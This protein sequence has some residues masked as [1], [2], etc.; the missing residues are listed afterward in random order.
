MTNV[1]RGNRREEGK[2]GGKGGGNRRKGRRK[3]RRR[4]TDNQE[5]RKEGNQC[6]RKRERGGGRRGK[7]G[8]AGRVE[9]RERGE[10]QTRRRS[11]EKEVE[12]G[13]GTP[14]QTWRRRT[15]RARACGRVGGA[16][17][18]SQEGKA[19]VGEFPSA[20]WEPLIILARFSGH[21]FADPSPDA[22]LHPGSSAADSVI[23]R[24]VL[25]VRKW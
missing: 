13:A 6:Y 8:L 14:T 24:G 22:V 9:E 18:R 23:L 12:G 16:E 20:N 2:R 17:S 5:E 19:A 10:E 21:V 7:N 25:F 4:R 3:K 15:S 1:E 11:R